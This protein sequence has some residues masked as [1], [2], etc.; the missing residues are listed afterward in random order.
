[1]SFFASSKLMETI[2]KQ[3]RLAKKRGGD[4]LQFERR[5]QINEGFTIK[6]E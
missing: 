4:N 1:M 3:I 5:D 2:K 6:K